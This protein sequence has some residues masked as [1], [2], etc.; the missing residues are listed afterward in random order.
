MSGNQR[1]W[2]LAE[3]DDVKRRDKADV[4][5]ERGKVGGD[6]KRCEVAGNCE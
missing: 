6:A 5:I 3:L 2:S 1:V 4:V